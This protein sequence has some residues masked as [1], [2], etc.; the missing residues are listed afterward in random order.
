MKRGAVLALALFTA[1]CDSFR[2]ADEAICAP[3]SG[4]PPGP[5]PVAPEQREA[6]SDCIWFWSY[7]LARAE[8]SIGD[9]AD[10]A[11][12]ACWSMI[13]HLEALTARNENRD[14]DA[15]RASATFRREAVYR[16]AEAR[17]GDCDSP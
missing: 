17:A 4:Q 3:P 10:A 8:G 6:T 9:V 16:I 11:V 15:N 12:S 7:R 1:G 13:E 2:G 14:P 5:R